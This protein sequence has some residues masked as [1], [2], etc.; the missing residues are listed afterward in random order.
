ML[1]SGEFWSRCLLMRVGCITGIAFVLMLKAGLCASAPAPKILVL[2]SLSPDSMALPPFE[3]ITRPALEQKL[4]RK[5]EIYT[6]YLE[7][8]RYPEPEHQQE[9]ALSLAGR[10]THRG[11]EM[12]VAVGF[13][14]LDFASRY[15]SL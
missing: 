2:Y 6:E 8:H 4:G 11:I 3:E 12:E 9:R 5:I 13:P 10:Y 15:R 1:H 7:L 14:A